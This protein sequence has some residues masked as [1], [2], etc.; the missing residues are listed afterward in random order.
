[1][2]NE[3]TPAPQPEPADE[4]A[5]EQARQRMIGRRRAIRAGL[6]AV[7]VLLTLRAVPASARWNN[8]TQSQLNCLYVNGNKAN[9]K[10]GNTYTASNHCRKG[11][12]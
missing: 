8:Y 1:M 4:Q 2:N 12:S 6:I 9:G 3:T 5:R 7:P 11:S 10:T